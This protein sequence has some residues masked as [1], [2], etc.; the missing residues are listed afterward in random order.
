MS[1]WHQSTKSKLNALFISNIS[2]TEFSFHWE[3]Q[4]SVTVSILSVPKYVVF[5]VLIA[6]PFASVSPFTMTCPIELH[7]N[8][9]FSSLKFI[10]RFGEPIT[11]LMWQLLNKVYCSLFPLWL[12]QIFLMPINSSSIRDTQ[13]H[14]L[15]P[16]MA[17]SK[18]YKQKTPKT[19]VL[20][21]L[22]VG[23]DGI[24]P[25]TLCL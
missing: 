20:E 5:T 17:Q 14:N 4:S 3:I 2:L 15:H 23:V 1:Q 12:S 11:F 19:D 22:S 24:E 6:K 13:V 16:E 25:P 21:V 10:V 18:V 8:V 7:C 9:S